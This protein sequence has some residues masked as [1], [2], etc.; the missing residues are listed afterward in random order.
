[1]PE[2]AEYKMFVIKEIISYC[3]YCK[4]IRINRAKSASAPERGTSGACCFTAASSYIKLYALLLIISAAAFILSACNPVLALNPRY[5]YTSF[6]LDLGESIPY[7]IEEYIDFDRLSA[8]DA[9]F[10]RENTE[11]LYDGKPANEKFMAEPGDH[12]V[13]IMYC[14][15][16]YRNYQIEITDK[17]APVIEVKKNI[18]T[19]MGIPPEDVD[20]ESMFTVS[21]NSGKCEIKISETEVDYTKAGKYP[22]TAVA[23]DASGNSSKAKAYV[24]VQ[25][26]KYGAVGTYVFVSIAKQHLTY[27]VDGKVAMDCPVVTGN[28]GNHNT[29]TGTFHL[30]YKSRNLVLKGS[31]D[32]GSKYAS[33]VN[34]WM[35]FLGSSYGLH[36]ASW[37][38]TFGGKIYQGNGSHGCVNMPIPAAAELFGMLEPGTPILI[39]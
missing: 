3:S 11:I 20:P 8:E 7:S 27:F 10:V 37:R 6:S 26:P 16:Q 9:A 39:Y 32:D 2:K 36:D 38:S 29:P 18:Y 19:F 30:I 34:Y 23:T 17:E 33:H 22:V 4:E 31:N 24:I 28:A 13:T 1:M 15:H 14:G 12:S 35:A 5:S 25:E 21:D